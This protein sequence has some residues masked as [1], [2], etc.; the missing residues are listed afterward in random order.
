LALLDF[1]KKFPEYSKNKFY[2]S[3]ESYAG[4]YIPTLAIRVGMDKRIPL[5]GVLIGNGITSWE[6]NDASL[7]YFE[8]YHGIIGEDLWENLLK[9]CCY[10]GNIESCIFS[11]N[12]T[13]QC[14]FLVHQA[15]LMLDGLDIYNVYQ[16]C[17]GGVKSS[18]RRYNF[19]NLFSNNKYVQDMK[20]MMPTKFGEDPP[21]SNTTALTTYLSHADVRTAIH[22][23]STVQAYTVCSE[24]VS[25]QYVINY[26]DMYLQYYILMD[27]KIR[28]SLFYGD[29]DMACNFIGGEWFIDSM[30]LP[31][32]TDRHSWTYTDS[33]GTLQ[34]GGFSKSFTKN[35]TFT[36]IR[37][38]GHM[39]PID[40][41][42][43][44]LHM[45][46]KFIS[47][48]DL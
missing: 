15:G 36:T 13:L 39:V 21:C 4:V 2:I 42:I 28:M 48:I 44:A 8:R 41:P 1:F 24:E 12:T 6:L 5:E 14:Q 11:R 16:P 9:Q 19:F 34:I 40:K 46:K 45:F 37:G 31:I 43:V 3:G 10:H 17:Y 23:P 20:K 18:R 7:L 29:V 47:N 32:K 38:S 25:N 33:D 27:M 26:Q 30:N 35:I 22:I